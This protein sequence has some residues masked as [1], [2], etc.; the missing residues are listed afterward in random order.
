MINV[1]KD[2]PSIRLSM[3]NQ[4]IQ[5]AVKAILRNLKGKIFLNIEKNVD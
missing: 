5:N 2:L 4:T 3:S 1:V